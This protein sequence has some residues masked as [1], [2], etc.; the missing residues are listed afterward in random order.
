[1]FK[2]GSS[3]FELEHGS[4][5]AGFSDDRMNVRM[6][7]EPENSF[8]WHLDIN[9]QEGPLIT[10][11][12]NHE[13]DYDDDYDDEDDY[14][15]DDSEDDYDDEDG[16][17]DYESVE[18]RLYHNNGFSLN[19]RSWKSVEG[20]SKVWEEE[21]NEDEEE[22]G[23]LYIFG[24]DPV[25]SGKIEFLKRKGTEFLV[26]WT[27]T[28]NVYWDEE[29]D[30][31]VP[32]EFEGWISFGG[33]LAC[34]DRISDRSELEEAMKEFINVDEFECVSEESHE[35]TGGRSYRWKYKPVEDR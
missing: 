13:K 9:M 4:F 6:C 19:V 28:A 18:P 16:Y 21:Y 8:S 11:S 12:K 10:Q 33:I 24:H 5:Y 30:T 7:C 22:A 34:C 25:T 29:Y 35:I 23:C 2:I 17:D 1:M 26:K 15:S 14:N 31:D 32:F 20:M 3:E 27:G